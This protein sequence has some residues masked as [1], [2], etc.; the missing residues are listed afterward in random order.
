[1]TMTL[2]IKNIGV[3]TDPIADKWYD[4]GS[5]GEHEFRWHVRLSKHCNG[6][7]I[8]KDDLLLYH[9]FVEDA[10]GHLARHVCGVARVS[11]DFDP[12]RM[13]RVP[14]D[15]DDQWPLVRKVTPLLVV[16]CA[17]QGPTLKQIGVKHSPR[18]GYK[19]VDEQAFAKAIRLL[20]RNALPPAHS[21]L[22]P[23]P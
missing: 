17:T 16:P 1:M 21:N 22:L 23:D 5:P 11:S 13:P 7:G 3:S 4:E 2:W 10:D 8:K 19:R 20:A 18:G 12:A 14:D 15:P 6:A 9:A